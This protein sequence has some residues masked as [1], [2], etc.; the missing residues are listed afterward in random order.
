M[1]ESDSNI[2]IPSAPRFDAVVSRRQFLQ[3][4]SGAAILGLTGRQEVKASSSID[5]P[6]EL[7]DEELESAGLT[8][9]TSV[10]FPY[11][12]YPPVDSWSATSDTKNKVDIYKAQDAI[13]PLTVTP[14]NEWNTLND[15]KDN[16]IADML[17]AQNGR[18][19]LQAPYPTDLKL[20]TAQLD[21]WMI[22]CEL[23][24][25]DG[26][27]PKEWCATALFAK[28]NELWKFEFSTPSDSPYRSDETFQASQILSQ[29]RFL[30]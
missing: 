17:S 30:K 29:I 27:S 26:V 25:K 9:F 19:D 10:N 8:K 16:H 6:P 18:T 28:E 24:G 7:T 14:M 4:V 3:A 15:Y 21:G 22:N 2:I 5:I 12:S 23:P 11:R 13:M 20:T 1:Q